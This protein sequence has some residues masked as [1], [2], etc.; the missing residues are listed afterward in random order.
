MKI[1][2]KCSIKIKLIS[3]TYLRCRPRS[4]QLHR[5]FLF[6]PEPSFE[7]IEVFHFLSDFNDLIFLLVKSNLKVSPSS[8]N[9]LSHAEFSI[10]FDFMSVHRFQI[11]W[12][13]FQS[14]NVSFVKELPIFLIFFLLT[15][16]A[17]FR[18]QSHG[19][20]LNYL[21]LDS[22]ENVQ[23]FDVFMITRAGCM[24]RCCRRIIG[25]RQESL[26]L[27]LID[28]RFTEKHHLRF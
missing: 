12:R 1:N 19:L 6:L 18:H 20:E 8:A 9:V 26:L 17:F 4:F 27:T 3:L 7:K 10:F 2:L 13:A 11:N 28:L 23:S 24:R 22:R 5:M 15:V 16:L 25:F 14:V 21:T